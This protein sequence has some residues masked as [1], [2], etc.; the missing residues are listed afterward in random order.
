MTPFL[1]VAQITLL[2]NIS[3]SKPLTCGE[4]PFKV[5]LFHLDLFS[6]FSS[7]IEG[8]MEGGHELKEE[9]EATSKIQTTS[10]LR[11]E[12]ADLLFTD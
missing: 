9:N 3:Y 5:I 10:Y 4:I 7:H 8:P 1:Q 11:L 6:G 2:K 12:D